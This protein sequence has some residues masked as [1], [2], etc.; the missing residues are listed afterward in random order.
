MKLSFGCALM[1]MHLKAHIC[2]MSVS[3][4]YYCYFY[5]RYHKYEYMYR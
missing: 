3:I 1:L 2:V 4:A 5:L